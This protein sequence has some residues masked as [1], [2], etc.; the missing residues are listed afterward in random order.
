[1]GDFL[2]WEM[3]EWGIFCKFTAKINNYNINKHCIDMRLK[4]IMPA[5]LVAAAVLLG[6]S[7][8]RAGASVYLVAWFADGTTSAFPF[9][10]RPVVRV[11]GN[12]LTV[13]NADAE[14]EYTMAELHKFTI[15]N[16][17][18]SGGVEAS[19]AVGGEV[20]VTGDEVIFGHC[21]PGDVVGAWGAN[22]VLCRSSRIDAD[23]R[24]SLS[25]AGLAPGIYIIKTSTITYKLLKR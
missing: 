24:G 17:P 3:V 10:G 13:V 23:G 15:E 19:V 21:K 16:E 6:G 20:R 22:G 4:K 12:V 8:A 14:L 25:I 7:V 2:A 1:M 5:M 9:A 11:D 18:P